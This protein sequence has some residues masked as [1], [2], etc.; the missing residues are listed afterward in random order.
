M[1]EYIY[2]YTFHFQIISVTKNKSSD[3]AFNKFLMN[4]ASLQDHV[5]IR[6]D[7]LVSW[8]NDIRNVSKCFLYIM[9]KL[10]FERC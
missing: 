3:F 1:Y 6:A 10:G 2:I 9:E 7:V 4:K 5:I 8:H